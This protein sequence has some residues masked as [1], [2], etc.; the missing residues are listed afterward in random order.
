[1]RHQRHFTETSRAFIGADHIGEDIGPLVGMCF[2]NPPSLEADPYAF[3]EGSLIGERLGCHHGAVDTILVRHGEDL[4]GGNVRIA[5][6]AVLGNRRTAFPHV[7]V[8]Q[9]NGEVGARASVSECRIAAGVQEIRALPKIARMLDPGLHGVGPIGTAAGEYRLP[10]RIERDVGLLVR[11]H[12]PGPGRRSR[13]RHAPID[14]M[15]GD[16]LEGRTIGFG[17]RPVG[18]R[19]LV[20]VLAGKQSGI[21]SDD[22]KT[23]RTGLEGVGHSVEQP[24]GCHVEAFIGSVFEACKR[25]SIIAEES[26]DEARTRFIGMFGDKAHERKCIDGRRHEQLLSACYIH[27]GANDELRIAI[28]DV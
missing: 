4:F 24:A 2:D 7:I 21:F 28:K 13:G 19:H 8:N 17:A 26:G 18:A 3:D 1:M 14:G 23:R 6:H 10:E 16:E 27:A 12:G 20:G 9:P 15:A 5:R 11:E 25:R 22:G